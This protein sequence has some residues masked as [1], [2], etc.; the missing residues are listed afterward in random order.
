MAKAASA[1]AQPRFAPVSLSHC[2][3][4][5]L[6]CRTGRCRSVWAP[7]WA[8][9]LWRV[10]REKERKRE[11]GFSGNLPPLF[12]IRLRCLHSFVSPPLLRP[13]PS[14]RVYIPCV[15]PL[16]PFACKR[17]K[18]V[19]VC[20]RERE[21]WI[22]HPRRLPP[23]RIVCALSFAS[24]LSRLVRRVICPLTR[25]HHEIVCA[26]FMWDFSFSHP[27]NVRVHA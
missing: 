11:R 10:S 20:A 16:S 23:G 25:A 18:R 6:L 3:L 26:P 9:S 19:H 13:R 21:K 12:F 22:G 1:R 5:L 15:P 27:R 2:A 8:R 24:L 7:R 17:L 4:L 14:P